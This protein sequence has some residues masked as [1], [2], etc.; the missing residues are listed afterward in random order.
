MHISHTYYCVCM[1]VSVGEKYICVCVYVC[2]WG[3][4]GR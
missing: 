2:A 3:G 4:G 1:Y